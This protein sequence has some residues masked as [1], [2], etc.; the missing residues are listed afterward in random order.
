MTYGLA[1]LADDRRNP[2]WQAVS[3][4]AELVG[5]LRSQ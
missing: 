1:P 4:L 3:H 5:P 2:Q